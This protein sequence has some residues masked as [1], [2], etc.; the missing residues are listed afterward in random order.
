M[1]TQERWKS[2]L[3]AG[4]VAVAAY[5]FGGWL[6]GTAALLGIGLVASLVRR[7]DD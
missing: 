7:F 5:I 1:Y 2:E 4:A 6:A 3:F